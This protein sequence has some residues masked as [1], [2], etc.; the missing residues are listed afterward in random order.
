MTIVGRLG[1]FRCGAAQRM[2]V[3]ASRGTAHTPRDWPQ[4]R[5]TGVRAFMRLSKAVQGP[6]T[7]TVTVT[8]CKRHVP[9]YFKE[10]GLQ[11]PCR[12]R[13]WPTHGGLSPSYPFDC[14]VPF[15]AHGLCVF[16]FLFLLLFLFSLCLPAACTLRRHGTCD[17]PRPRPLN[18]TEHGPPTSHSIRTARE[19]AAAKQLLPH[20]RG[21]RVLDTRGTAAAGR[22][23]GC[24][25][26][27]SCSR[28]TQSILR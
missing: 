5:E 7:A 25:P 1:L 18:R 15:Y 12:N 26:Q 11:L 8:V 19:S 16:L 10:P 27:A 14:F 17:A 9:L 28:P 2:L 3:V 13:P 23:Q 21:S 4:A 20:P 24:C 6:P 22:R